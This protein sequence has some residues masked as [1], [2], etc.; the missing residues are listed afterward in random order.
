[1]EFIEYCLPASISR[2]QNPRRR[3]YAATWKRRLIMMTNNTNI[4]PTQVDLIRSGR[5]RF[6]ETKCLESQLHPHSLSLSLTGPLLNSACLSHSH[7]LVSPV[8]ILSINCL[9]SADQEHAAVHTPSVRYLVAVRPTG[10]SISTA[11]TPMSSCTCLSISTDTLTDTL[12]ERACESPSRADIGGAATLAG[13]IS[14][15]W[16]TA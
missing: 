8:F 14:S 1:M 15:H 7:H 3:R 5:R 4:L 16:G 9:A 13:S 11:S 10:R 12:Q 6:K 2:A